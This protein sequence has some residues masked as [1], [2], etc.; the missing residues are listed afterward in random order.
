M[1]TYPI[2]DTHVHLWDLSNL[3]Y[4]WLEEE[5]QINRNFLLKE[6]REAT[7]ELDVQQ[8]IFMQC[9]CVPEQAVEEARWVAGLMEEEPKLVGMV[10]RARLERGTEAKADIDALLVA[11]PKIKGIR[12]LLQGEPS[13]DFCL[14]RDFIEGVSLLAEYDLPF[15]LCLNYR[16]L[17]NALSFAR[18]LPEV[19][20]VIDHIAKPDIKAGTDGPEFEQWATYMAEFARLDHVHCKLSSIA[21]EA[22]QKNWQIDDLR[23]YVDHVMEHFGV[24]KCFFAGD[25]PVSTLAATYKTSVDTL[26]ELLSDLTDAQMRA[27]FSENGK[28]FYGV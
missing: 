14:Q 1:S 10:A 16:H 12:R 22:D 27:I 15:D 13:L 9:D 17:P 2:V 21:T 4:P 8:M 23:P 25:W 6:Y 3:S 11:N 28:A 5:P 7:S 19:K 20:M 26:K 24:K 18:Q